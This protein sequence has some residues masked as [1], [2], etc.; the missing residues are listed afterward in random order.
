M[1]FFKIHPACYSDA[2]GIK[3]GSNQKVTVKGAAKKL[4]VGTLINPCEMYKL[5]I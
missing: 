5:L 1:F 2:N 3:P 4:Y